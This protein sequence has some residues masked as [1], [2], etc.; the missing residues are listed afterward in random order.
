MSHSFSSPEIGVRCVE[1][2]NILPVELP[3]LS[4]SLLLGR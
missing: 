1:V 3:K 4:Q 2:F